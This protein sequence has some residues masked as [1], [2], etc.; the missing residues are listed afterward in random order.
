[1]KDRTD[2]T[3]DLSRFSGLPE[4]VH[5]LHAQGQKYVI[6]LVSRYIYFAQAYIS[7]VLGLN[8]NETKVIKPS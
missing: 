1:M 6:V 2:F 7:L 3:W 8:K 5:Q 4:F